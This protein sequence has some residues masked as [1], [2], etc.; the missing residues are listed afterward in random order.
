MNERPAFYARSGGRLGDAW[1]LLHPPYTLWN[2]SYVVWGAALAPDIHWG[3]FAATLAAFLLGTGVASHALDE[4]NG[5]PL[6]TGFSDR[7]LKLMAAVS[8]ALA[9]I[10]ALACV[11]FTSWWLL[12]W[13]LLGA[14]LVAAYALEW[15]GGLFHGPWGFALAWGAFPVFV[16]YWVQAQDVSFAALLMAAAAAVISLA[17]RELSTPARFV[18]RKAT[19]VEVSLNT[20]NGE[21][22]W[23]RARLMAG[24]E[25]P[26]KLLSWAVPLLAVALLA[27]R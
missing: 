7:Q 5:R 8:L 11:T 24:W 9:L 6:G 26:L 25:K 15:C 17:Q 13:A 2:V 3:L 23:N 18:R 4:L 22:H 16:G 19:R 20:E 12:V 10:L 1:T 14:F 27:S 21:T